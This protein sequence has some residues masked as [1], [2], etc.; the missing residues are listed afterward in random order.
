M[1][2]DYTKIV[3]I[4]D[5]SG[6]MSS[7]ATDMIGGYNRFIED[8][9]K[10][11]H[12]TCD[13]SFYQFNEGYETIYE[14]TP[15]AFVKN[16]DRD[17]FIPNGSTALYDAIGR[18]ILA[19][20]R[21]L[22]KLA[23]S[24]RPDKVLIA[25][26]TDGY[27]NASK[28]FT[29]EKVKKMIEEQTSKYSW[30]FTYLGANQD[31][32][33]VGQNIGISTSRSLNYVANAKGANAMFDSLTSNVSSLRMCSGDSVSFS[34]SDNDIKKQTEAGATTP[35]PRGAIPQPKPEN[36]PKPTTNP[37]RKASVSW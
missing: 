20:G 13:V 5:R 17:T 1:K 8:Q 24:E 18:T 10:L 26:I 7:I 33:S 11:N 31:A 14:N 9:K 34:Y 19:V 35:N 29:A 28:E 12:G 25:I 21:Q 30:I 6:S 37:L 22:E 4:V 2:K 3:F 36:N 15:V 23:E 16:L 32:W 27:E